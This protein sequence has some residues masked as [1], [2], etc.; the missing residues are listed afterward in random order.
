MTDTGDGWY[1]A[2]YRL[3]KAGKFTISLQLAGA[4]VT[5]VFNIVTM[6]EFH[7]ISCQIKTTE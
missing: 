3:T 4:Q 7:S 1:A 2:A 6:L 5:P